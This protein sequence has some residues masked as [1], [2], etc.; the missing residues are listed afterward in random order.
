[1]QASGNIRMKFFILYI[2]IFSCTPSSP[3][4]P[5][6]INEQNLFLKYENRLFDNFLANGQVISKNNDGTPTDLG[7][8]LLF[9]GLAIG[10]ANCD[11]VK[12]LLTSLEKMEAHYEDYLVRFNPLPLEFAEKTD[13]ISRDGATGVLY[14]LTLAKKRC[15]SLAQEIHTILFRWK[16]AVSDSFTLYPG[17]YAAFITPSFKTFWDLAHGG[18]MNFLKYEDLIL[19][20]LATTLWI[21]LSKSACYPIHLDT[22]QFLT[23]EN[24]GYPILERHKA[25]FCSLSNGM[26]LMLTDWFCERN[27][28]KIL[29]WLHN[30]E[31]SQNVYM[32]HRCIWESTD[33]NSKISPRIDYLLLFRLITQGSRD[34]GTTSSAPRAK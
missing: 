3:V 1:M 12:V 22:L 19:S 25:E 30:P 29:A 16:N 15:P 6:N 27:K 34:L 18:E 31:S 2:L 23:L 8:S 11:R 5:I 32:H 13:F 10:S 7:D 21:K 4:Q 33:G 24:L 26:G 17:S 9:S 28:D 14:G 20:I